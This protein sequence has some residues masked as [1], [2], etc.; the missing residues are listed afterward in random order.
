MAVAASVVLLSLSLSRWSSFHNETF[1]LAF[2]G[3]MAWGSLHGIFWDPIVGAH[4]L[5]LH[6]SVVILPLGVASLIPGA[7][8]PALLAAQAAAVGATAIPIGRIAARRFGPWGAVLGAMAWLL[9]PNIGHVAT[10][11]WHPGTLA[12]LPLSFALDALDRKAPRAFIL[13]IAAVLMCRE[14]LGLCTGLLGLVAFRSEASM[15][16]V[17]LVS[18]GV[19]FGYVAIFLFVLLPLLGPEEGSVQLHFGKWGDSLPAAAIA[20]LGDPVGLLAHLADPERLGYVPI[21]LA[22]V[23]FLPLLSGRWLI[24][25]LPIFAINLLSDWPTTTHLDSHYQ[26]TLLPFLIVA[27][28]DGAAVLSRRVDEKLVG[29]GLV[30]ALLITHGLAGGTPLSA[31]FDATMF[32][33]DARSSAAR[34]AVA[35]IPSGQ[36][37]QAPYALMPHLVER[38]A[39]SAPPPPDRNNEWIIF[40]AWHRQRFAQSEDL[41]RTSEEPT[42]RDWLARAD[43]GLVLEQEPYL[44]LHRG[45]DPRAFADALSLFQTETDTSHPERLAECL[46]LVDWALWGDVLRLDLLATG[47]CD[48]DLAIRIGTGPRPTRV[49]LLFEGILSPVHLRE[50]EVVQSRHLLSPGEAAA[51]LRGEIRV[52]LLRS[53]GARPA[54][55]DPVAIYLSVSDP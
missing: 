28:I 52:G 8:I 45:H 13:S 38:E 48:A 42:I 36:S 37:V 19:S 50:G 43:Y 24:A 2:Y 54:H 17:G 49:D 15:K 27:T 9:Y 39:I 20:M 6:V 31:D 44:V 53:S 1:D 21:L 23:A 41:L 55:A 33:Q 29:A 46:S 14:D 26:T 18:A 47:S 4:M 5:G 11:E 3:R 34:A 51:L 22:P 10:Y 32:R 30:I 7:I 25:A 35:E 12:V 16:K 40:D